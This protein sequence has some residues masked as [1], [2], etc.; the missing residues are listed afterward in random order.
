MIRAA[1]PAP[2]PLARNFRK[3][4]DAQSQNGFPFCRAMNYY[5]RLRSLPG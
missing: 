1:S 4:Q 3:R 2:L 5:C